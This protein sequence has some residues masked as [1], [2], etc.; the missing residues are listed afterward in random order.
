MK[1]AG[2]SEDN[3]P[4]LHLRPANSGRTSAQIIGHMSVG[5]EVY[6][7]PSPFFSHMDLGQYGYF[8]MALL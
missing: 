6:V 8:I 2:S 3:P 4:G 1:L 5:Q 7:E